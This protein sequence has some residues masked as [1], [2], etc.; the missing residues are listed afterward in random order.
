MLIRKANSYSSHFFVIVTFQTFEVPGKIFHHLWGIL[1]KY[2]KAIY[3]VHQNNTQCSQKQQWIL[4]GSHTYFDSTYSS[5]VHGMK[6]GKD[7]EKKMKRWA[8]INTYTKY[9]YNC[10]PTVCVCMKTVRE[11][12]AINGFQSLAYTNYSSASLPV[13]QVKM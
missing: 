5:N 6:T 8:D 3:I 2:F 4:G 9:K 10:Y 1:K 7:K 11:H 12:L 13:T